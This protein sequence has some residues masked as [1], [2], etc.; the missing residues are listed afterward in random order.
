ME[1]RVGG[2]LVGIAA[3]RIAC[4]FELLDVSISYPN[5]CAAKLPRAAFSASAGRKP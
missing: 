5:F 2:F 1:A 4:E 3:S